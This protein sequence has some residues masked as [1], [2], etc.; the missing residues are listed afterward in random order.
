MNQLRPD[1]TLASYRD[2]V[3]KMR[4]Q[5]YELHALYA[6]DDIVSLAGIEVRVNLYLG[7]HVYIYDLV[8]SAAH[9]SN[10]YGEMLLHFVHEYAH[11]CGATCVAL[12]SGLAR[13]DAH[14]FYTDKMGYAITSYSFRKQL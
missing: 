10:G 14:R 9:R 3:A 7:K 11:D 12:E 8:T 5:G 1:L 2:L 6:D 13:T 4:P